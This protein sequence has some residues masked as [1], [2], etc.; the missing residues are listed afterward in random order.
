MINIG[1]N[2]GVICGFNLFTFLNSTEWLNANI[3]KNNPRTTPL[4][5][6][7]MYLYYVAFISLMV[8]IMNIL[9]VA[10]EKI[11]DDRTKDLCR[12][13]KVMPKM[14]AH[15]NMRKLIGFVFVTRIFFYLINES[16]QLKLLRNGYLNIPRTM[17]STI[18]LLSYP[19]TLTIS[20]FSIKFIQKGKIIHIYHWI[21]VVTVLVGFFKF[22][23]YHHLTTSKDLVST[24]YLLIIV[25]IF[26][27]FNLSTGFL[28]GYYNMIIDK[29]VANTS[30]TC[31]TAL[32]NQTSALPKTIGLYLTSKW[33]F[34][35]FCVGALSVQL[36]FLGLSYPYQFVLDKRGKKE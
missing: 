28:L 17:L 9:F 6:H 14:I 5:T 4:V 29:S 31:L 35:T 22:L 2:F 27:A 23:V 16:L 18:D 7:Q 26:N 25:A 19:I 3:F 20:C 12:V 36:I 13:I 11:N 24:E 32:M 15:S 10:E 21:M 34:S 33:E 1:Q 8:V 30:I